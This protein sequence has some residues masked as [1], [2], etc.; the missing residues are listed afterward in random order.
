MTLIVL[1]LILVTLWVVFFSPYPRYGLW[2]AAGMGFW[3]V[4][5]ILRM[6]MQW[7]FGLSLGWGY[8]MSFMLLLIGFVGL[9]ILEDR[10][11]QQ[12]SAP[13]LCIE[14]TPVYGEQTLCMPPKRFIRM[15]FLR[16]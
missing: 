14:H 15:K 8:I 12:R 2:F 13:P 4:V 11:V 3:L 1:C 9:L 5:E 16:N 6:M 7:T 10:K